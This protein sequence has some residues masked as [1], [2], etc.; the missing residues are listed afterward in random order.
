MSQAGAVVQSTLIVLEPS[1][2]ENADAP[3]GPPAPTPPPRDL[4]W[5]LS[6]AFEFFSAGLATLDVV[7]DALVAAQFHKEGRTGWFWAV[8][9]IMFNSS[10][11]FAI[12][13]VETGIK[14]GNLFGA[15]GSR[16]VDW[17]RK[18]MYPPMILVGQLLP[19][20]N[21]VCETWFPKEDLSLMRTHPEPEQGTR[22]GDV[23]AGLSV[24]VESTAEH[25]QLYQILAWVQ[26]RYCS[27][28]LFIVET[29][30]ESIPQ[31]LVQL[32]AITTAGD[33]V[34][35]VQVVS[36]ALSV[37]SIVSKAYTV[38]IGFDLRACVFKFT[39]ASYDVFALF[40]TFTAL[41]NGV[42]SWNVW[43]LGEAGKGVSTMTM[44]WAWKTAI[45]TALFVLASLV[46]GALLARVVLVDFAR[47][48]FNLKTLPRNVLG[49]SNPRSFKGVYQTFGWLAFGFA[50]W[51]L[52]LVPALVAAEGIKLS[53][54]VAVLL[55]WE[56]VWPVSDFVASAFMFVG[57]AAHGSE[58]RL[59]R[60]KYVN[61]YVSEV[62]WWRYEREKRADLPTKRRHQLVSRA[63]KVRRLCRQKDTTWS[64]LRRVFRHMHVEAIVQGLEQM[65]TEGKTWHI[66]VQ[67][68]AWIPA[69]VVLAL[70]SSFWLLF[71]LISLA[72]NYEQSALSL[73]CLSGLGV[74]LAV[75]LFL[76]P[77]MIRHVGVL[78]VTTL[79]HFGRIEMV[80]VGGR[81]CHKAVARHMQLMY[82]ARW[83]DVLIW[84]MRPRL[85][86]DTCYLIAQFLVSSDLNV[87]GLSLA[88]CQSIKDTSRA[89]QGRLT[90]FSSALAP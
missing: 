82:W 66:W 78:D 54:I 43:F 69:A 20:V 26:R 36:L 21:W 77:H 49:L 7:A 11:L 87:E 27:H 48:W 52:L 88:E 83:D 60:A 1:D 15:P 2:P 28:G 3:A 30:V 6:W 67:T 5:W 47:T 72:T 73:F 86:V 31:S 84:A 14:A 85:P 32:L 35:A 79:N 41:A 39:L 4:K 12:V 81:H 13:S 45:F 68:V 18:V 46:T 89:S 58:E 33:R 42:G 70:G 62:L 56:P 61:A 29:A 53:G 44:V 50:L 90:A 51:L 25:A 8:V 34:S 75:A 40:Y 24:S 17:K 55:L 57:S 23:G 65:F 9:L 22:I 37:S 80:E 59:E 64:D 16:M 63:R 74:C 76:T 38:S 19:V 10:I 71:P